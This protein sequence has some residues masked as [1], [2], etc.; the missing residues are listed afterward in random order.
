M[1]KTKNMKMNI[2]VLIM[3]LLNVMSCDKISESDDVLTLQRQN[4]YGNELMLDGIYYTEISSF[5][6]IFY[7]RYALFRDG[8]IRDLGAAPE[9]GS[10]QFLTGNSKAD[11][12]VFQ[13]DGNEIKFERWYPSSGGPLRSFVR[14]GIILNDTTFHIKESYRM[15][16]GQKTEIMER[17]EIYH[18]LHFSPKPD[19]ANTFMN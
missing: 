19:S 7:Q 3:V 16:D 1:V 6:G 10:A 8:I 15:R 18:F 4:Y 12:G 9:P 2:K 11:W 5:D 17:D 14:S 13:I